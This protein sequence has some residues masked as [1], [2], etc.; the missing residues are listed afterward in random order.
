MNDAPRENLDSLEIILEK[1]CTESDL[2]YIPKK[3]V[4]KKLNMKQVLMT[5]TNLK[6]LE[7][8]RP[9]VNC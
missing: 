3:S 7:Y 9:P 5:N 2:R 4:R 8:I 1:Y 6:T